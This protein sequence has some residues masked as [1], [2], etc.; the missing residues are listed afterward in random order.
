MMI[1][2]KSDL[3]TTIVHHKSTRKILMPNSHVKIITFI[4]VHSS[5]FY[6]KF[7]SQ[8]PQFKSIYGC[9]LYTVIVNNIA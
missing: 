8:E 2:A 5:F 7:Y 9:K 1:F 6:Y 4:F 3:I